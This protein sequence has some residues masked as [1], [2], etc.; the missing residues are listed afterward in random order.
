MPREQVPIFGVVSTLISEL[1]YLMFLVQSFE[2]PILVIFE[3]TVVVCMIDLIY[4]LG[5]G[6]LQSCFG[7]FST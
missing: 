6:G 3:E 1:D 5:V 2:V 4:G 7:S